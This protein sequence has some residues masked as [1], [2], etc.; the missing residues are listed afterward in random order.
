MSTPRNDFDA[1]A[2]YKEI[3]SANEGVNFENKVKE[4]IRRSSDVKE[5]IRCEVWKLLK[6]KII[7][8]IVGAFSFVLF[9]LFSELGSRLIQKI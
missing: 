2:A 1:Q 7:W 5:E 3:E 4:A 6:E 8:V 9:Q